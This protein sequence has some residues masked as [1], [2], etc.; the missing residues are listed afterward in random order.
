[1]PK[2]VTQ[3]EAQIQSQKDSLKD[4]RLT[5]PISGRV[6]SVE[7]K[8]GMQ[9]TSA[10]TELTAATKPPSAAIVIDSGGSFVA[11]TRVDG[12]SAASIHVGDPVQLALPHNSSAN[13]T[14]S[15]IGIISTDPS[16]TESA[17]VTV[18]ITGKPAGIYPG[19]TTEANITLVEK[20]HVL[21]VPSDAVHTSGARTYVD[22]IVNGHSVEHDVR[23]GAVGTDM[24]QIVSGL[25]DGTRVVVPS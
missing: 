9:V 19:M 20:R 5:A 18:M 2:R 8:P 14:V 16:G 23:V 15:A 7:I 24:T 22:E 21:S 25:S 1:M 13:G 6:K 3:A 11:E 12:S 10:P 17:P 4:D